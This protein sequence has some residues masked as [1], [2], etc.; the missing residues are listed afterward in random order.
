MSNL[1]RPADPSKLWIIDAR[2]HTVTCEISFENA[3]SDIAFTPDGT[4]VYA[5]DQSGAVFVIDATSHVVVDSL[6]A[7]IERPGRIAFAPDG[8]TA[9]ILSHRGRTRLESG[10]ASLVDLASRTVVNSVEVGLSPYDVVVT[11]DRALAFVVNRWSSYD[12][13]IIDLSTGDVAGPP[14]PLPPGNRS[15]VGNFLTSV[16]VEPR[17]QYVYVTNADA[18]QVSVIDVRTQQVIGEPIPV[19]QGPMQIQIFSPPR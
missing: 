2:T 14:I 11:P 15:T 10:S 7:R 5:L 18:N 8:Q 19:G 4:Q 13:Y 17:G 16:T 1:G 12:V 9:V 3:L 6:A